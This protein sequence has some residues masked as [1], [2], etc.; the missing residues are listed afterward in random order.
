MG[1]TCASGK[2]E[3]AANGVRNQGL[4]FG[5]C[6]RCGRDLIRS[7]RQWRTVPQGFRVVWRRAADDVQLPLDLP[8]AGR[9]LALRAPRRER[10]ALLVA[11]ELAMLGVRGLAGALALRVRLW[12]GAMTAPRRRAEPVLQLRA[13]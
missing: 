9:A 1:R 10:N 6:G 4:E 3:V 11:L 12:A 5:R 8:P 2:H 13:S 7:R